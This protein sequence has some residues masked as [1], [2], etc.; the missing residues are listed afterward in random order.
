MR[1]PGIEPGQAAWEAAIITIRPSTHFN[2]IFPY[3]KNL[4][5]P[6]GTFLNEYCYLILRSRSSVG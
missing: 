5:K 4:L 3:F 2:I 1:R 6:G